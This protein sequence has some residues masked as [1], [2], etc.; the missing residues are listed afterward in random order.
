M[1]DFPAIYPPSTMAYNHIFLRSLSVYAILFSAFLF[2]CSSTDEAPVEPETTLPFNI[3]V[4]A[5]G[6]DA[7]Y[8]LNILGNPDNKEIFNLT[9]SPG[10]PLGYQ[11]VYTHGPKVT[12]FNFGGGSY[13]F[14]QKDVIT[15]NSFNRTPLCDL[16]D[17]ESPRFPLTSGEKLALLTTVSTGNQEWESYLKIYDPAN[18]N[19]SRFYINDTYIHGRSRAQL[20][21]DRFY[22]YNAEDQAGPSLTVLS[23]NTGDQLGKLTF[24]KEFR[25]MMSEDQLYLSF[26]DGTYKTYQL[27]ALSLEKEGTMGITPMKNAQGI[28]SSTFKGNKM[29][30]DYPYAQPSPLSTAPAIYDWATNTVTHGGDFYLSD[31]INAIAMEN[32]QSLILTTAKVNLEN[33]II[34]AGYKDAYEQYKGGVAY[35]N[36]DGEVLMNIPLDY[37]PFEILIGD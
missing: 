6:S 9:Q 10:V 11:E 15:G 17:E 5:K 21:K 37:V 29:S 12:F 19:C 3:S 23:A 32:D 13:A 18:S 30:F 28:Y 22:L 8:Q 26:Q 4:F 16:E 36:F 34:V 24:E 35:L 7:I 27:N 14:W 1:F 31:A 25:A 2:S 20:H 33:N